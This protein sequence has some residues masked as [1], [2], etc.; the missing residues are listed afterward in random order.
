VSEDVRDRLQSSLGS[1]YAIERELAG[2]GMSRVFVAE[3]TALGR[4]VVLKVLPPETAAGVS[5]E[6]FKREISL[7]ARLQHPHIVPLHT[8]GVADGLPYFTMPFVEGES[9]RVRLARQ[10]EL[11]VS[12]ALRVLREIAAALAYAHERGIVHRDIKPDNVLLSGGSAMVTD[13]GVAKALSASSNAEHGGFTSLGIALGTPAYMAPEQASAEPGVD[14]RA[15]IYGFGALAYEVLTGQPPFVGR[16]ASSLLAAHV[17]EAPEPVSKRRPALPPPL[18]ALIMRCLE[19]RPADRPQSAAEVVHQLDDITTPS[20]GTQPTSAVPAT[21]TSRAATAPRNWWI[22]AALVLL[23]AVGA[24]ALTNLKT[25][26]GGPD[27]AAAVAAKKIAVLPFEPR[28]GDTSNTYLADGMSTD[29]TTALGGISGLHVVPRSSAFALRGKTAEDAGRALSADA[30]V[31]GMVGRV[32]NVLRVTAAVVNIADG[33]VLWSYKYDA[34][35]RDLYALHDSIASAIVAALQLGE[36]AAARD[37]LSKRRTRS[38]EAH[39]LVLRGQF[40]VSQGTESELRRAIE[41]FERAI[42]ID[43]LYPDAWSGL[44]NAWFNLADDFVSPHEAIPPMRKAA[45]RSVALDHGSADAHAV[46]GALLAAYDRRYDDANR[47]FIAALA[48]DSTNEIAVLPYAFNLEAFGRVDSALAVARRGLRHN[49]LSVTASIPAFSTA[50]RNG[51]PDSA[52]AVCLRLRAFRPDVNTCDVSLALS[53][54]RYAEAVALARQRATTSPSGAEF[55][56][57]ARV[58]ALAGQQAEAARELQ[59]ALEFTRKRYVR[60][61]AVAGAYVA[62][63]DFDKAIEWLER[64]L[65]AD[66]ANMST[67]NISDLFVPLRPDP[68]F[69][70]IVQRAGLPLIR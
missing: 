12:E 6:R 63:G 17:S 27:T 19:K 1:A 29:L 46:L 13:F 5:V 9:L 48:I 54:R 37:R 38:P 10:G 47:E 23:V 18:A 57:L 30:V 35:E 45:E 33:T 39:D 3:E 32:G 4:R 22:A 36:S 31:E 56:A 70:S 26:R 24:W 51:Q 41:F 2:G 64:G 66:A 7:A 42:R 58:L 68:R 59:H 15:D 49:P 61:D 16:T 21:T 55:A 53:Q 34:D 11:P 44:A 69:Q 43:S 60:E 52:A 67:I 50:L 28:G 65:E 20:G 25:A 14:H 62:L 40:L 8:A